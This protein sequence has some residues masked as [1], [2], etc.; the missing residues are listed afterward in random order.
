MG[1]HD[2]SEEF[3]AI[4]LLSPLAPGPL[5]GWLHLFFWVGLPDVIAH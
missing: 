1:N 2:G 5:L 4:L 3:G